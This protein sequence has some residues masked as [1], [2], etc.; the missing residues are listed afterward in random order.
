MSLLFPEHIE[1]I[2]LFPAGM[3]LSGLWTIVKPF[4]DPVS[5][6]KV[7]IL[8]EN[9]IPNCLKEIID[10]K[11]LS[12]DYGGNTEFEEADTPTSLEKV[13]RRSKK[14]VNVDKLNILN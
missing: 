7:V 9:D 6:T 3:I 8:C 13:K 5:A 2:L 10:I 11:E 4:V 1:R 12:S 14:K